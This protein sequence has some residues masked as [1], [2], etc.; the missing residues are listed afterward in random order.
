L[1]RCDIH[2]FLR[3]FNQSENIAHAENTIRH[4]GRIEGF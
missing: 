4:T 2:A 1:S 3:F